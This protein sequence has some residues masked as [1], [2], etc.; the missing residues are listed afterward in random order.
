MLCW[1]W[2]RMGKKRT[3]CAYVKSDIT[4]HRPSSDWLFNRGARIRRKEQD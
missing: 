1:I 2:P 4:A 3:E